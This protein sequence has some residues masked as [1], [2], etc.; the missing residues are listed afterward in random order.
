[1]VDF[2]EVTHR[3]GSFVKKLFNKYLIK[4]SLTDNKEISEADVPGILCRK[5]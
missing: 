4:D 5:G 1:M 3:L 2:L